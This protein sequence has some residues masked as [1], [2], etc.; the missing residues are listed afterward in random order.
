MVGTCQTCQW[1]RCV[2]VLW[3]ASTIPPDNQMLPL[4]MELKVSCHSFPD[5]QTQANNEAMTGF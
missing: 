1:V 3:T 4:I 5:G 2:H